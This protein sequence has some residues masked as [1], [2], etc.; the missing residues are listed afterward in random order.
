MSFGHGFSSHIVEPYG[1]GALQVAVVGEAPG[2]EE[3]DN[4]QP[5]WPGAQAGSVLERAIRRSGYYRE[6]FVIANVVPS[7]PPNNHLEG[8]RYEAEAIEWGRPQLD[9]TIRR[10]RPRVIL[11]LGNVATR[12]LTGLVGPKLGVSSLTGFVLPSRYDGVSVIPCFHPSY[13]R[14]GKMSHFGILLRALK[15]AIAVARANTQPVTP[16]P[17]APP[18]G[19]IMYPTEEQ[20]NDYVNQA[21]SAE[22]LAYDIETPYSTAEDSAEEADGAHTIK[23]IQFS[24]ARGT[25][26]FFP[27]REPYI[28]PARRL[29]SSSVAKLGWNNWRFDDPVLRAN[30]CH[31]DGES[32][33]L[34]WA[35]HHL[36]P[37][38]PRGLQFAAAQMGWPWPW[39]HLAM[40]KEQFYGIVDCDALQYLA[41]LILGGLREKG[42][43]R[44]Y[45]RHVVALNPVLERMSARGMPVDPEAFAEVVATL[46]ADHKAAKQRMQELVPDEIKAKKVYK[47]PRPDGVQVKVL[48]WTPSNQGLTNYMR[49]RGHAVPKHI[50]TGKDTTGHIEIARLSRSTRDPLYATVIQYRKAQTILKDHIVNWTPGPDGRVHTTFYFDPSTGQLSSRRPN[51]QNAPKHDDPEFGGYAKLFRSMVKARPG[52]TII[53]FDYSSFHVQTLGFEGQDKVLMRMGRLDIHSF[54]TAAFLHLNTPERMIAMPDAELKAYLGQVKKEHKYTRDA[55][56]KHALLGYN[57]GM[58]AGKLYKQYMEFFK[59]QY[60]AK[61]VLSLFDQLFPK[62]KAYRDSIVQKAHDQGYLTSRHGYVRYFW[63][64]NRWRGGEWTHGDDR[65]A[66]LCFYTQNDA[67]GE[68]KDRILTIAERGLDERYGLLNTI[69]DSL[70]FECANELV[71][72]CVRDIRAIMESPSL[73][74][75][76]PVVAPE[77]LSVAVDVQGGPSWGTMKGL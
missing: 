72:D 15:L 16:T 30:S 63:E 36:Q 39:K 56:C 75:V 64:V 18:S 57:N 44:G 65:E 9:E 62:A 10:F 54:T 2:Q 4:G 14:R 35:W 66:A 74:L 51:V 27:W 5:F 37:D 13:L 71:S 33:D 8:A 34:M 19:Y 48:P 32:H 17:D 40:A 70:I 28:S 60:E 25:G 58:G 38:L 1:T 23:S 12:A 22:W 21:S 68:L 53:E 77:G 73:V 3:D 7:R 61:T 24:S 42:L 47:K 49:H 26:I 67:H 6:Q 41:P 50:K 46:E 29:L 59:S 69:H 52:Y 31:I 45:S 11:A 43:W 55:Q 20:A 76:D